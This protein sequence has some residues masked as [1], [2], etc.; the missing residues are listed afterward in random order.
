MGGSLWSEAG[1]KGQRLP[2]VT[3][4]ALCHPG[5][6]VISQMQEPSHMVVEQA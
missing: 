6:P 1:N 5:V 2:D 4:S 3:G